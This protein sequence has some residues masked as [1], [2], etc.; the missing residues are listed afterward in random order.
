MNSWEKDLEPLLVLYGNRRHPLEY[1]N[2]YQLLVMI[3]LSA[4]TADNIINKLAPEFFR[5]FP[6][7]ED[8]KNH[9]PEDLYP[10][11]RNV[12]GFMKKAGWIAEIARLVGDDSGIPHTME[13]LVKL[14]GIGRKS[15]NIL[16]RESGDKAEGIMVDLHVARVAPRLGVAT[17]DK[18]ERIEKELMSAFG[19]EKWNDIGMSLSYHGREIC[20]P[21]PECGRCVV[22]SVCNYYKTEV[23]PRTAHEK[24]SW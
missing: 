24:A 21:K 7:M 22:N 16:I 12:R 2:R 13:E 1:K 8:V 23:L 4:Q 6:S 19:D 14:P 15:A 10:Y 20:R 11:I 9:D 3:I 5:A 18:P 17:T